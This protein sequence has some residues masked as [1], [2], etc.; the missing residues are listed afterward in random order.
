MSVTPEALG[1]E[2]IRQ[3]SLF[4]H[5]KEISPNTKWDD[6]RTPG[7]EKELNDLLIAV[8][9]E[10]GWPSGA[11]YCA[12]FAEGVVVLAMRRLDVDESIV[13]KFRKLMTPHCMTSFAN[14]KAVGKIS[15]IPDAGAIWLAQ[16]GT[17]DM[18]HAG[19]VRVAIGNGRMRTT[20]GNTSAEFIDDAKERQGDGI[21]SRERN[22]RLN[23]KLRTVGFVNP[24][25]ILSL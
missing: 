13:T 25:A 22:M 18:G 4:L 15:Q 12:G 20:E 23:G 14:F 24:S 8:M 2:I 3:S 21:Y 17:T 16:H 19:I 11:P 10:A 9:K 1:A 7:P 5:L 6:P